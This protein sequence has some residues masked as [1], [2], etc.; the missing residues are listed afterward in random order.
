MKKTL[1]RALSI[2]ICLTAI[3]YT[4]VFTACNPKPDYISYVSELRKDIFTGEQDNFSVVIYSGTK[5]SPAVFDGIK[6][7]TALTLTF[8]VTC[9]EEVG[10]SIKICFETGNKKYEKT[11]DFN[12]VK[13]T[14]CC[15]VEVNA[16]PEK[17]LAVT[18]CYGESSTVVNTLSRLKENTISYTKALESAA[19]KASDFLS[20]HTEGGTLK[21]EIVLRL[22]CENDRNYYYVGFVCEEGLKR[23]Y[24]VNGENG[25]IIAEKTN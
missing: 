17:E 13:S 7:Q 23:A 8:K 5:E 25:E 4:L 6:N 18:L 19:E 12:P 10:E 1:S 14:L 15:D 16:L 21:A 3:C 9:K 20:E 22:L 11:L 2:F 24:L